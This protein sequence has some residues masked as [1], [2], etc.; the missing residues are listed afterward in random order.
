MTN[1]LLGTYCQN[2]L[3]WNQ[4][5]RESCRKCGATLMI[6]SR[7]H[8]PIPIK[9][10]EDEQNFEED[11]NLNEHLLERITGIEE[12]IRRI[13][14]YLETVSDQLGRLER[15]EVMLRNGLMSLVQEMEHSKLLDSQAFS[16]RWEELVEE[17]L[18]LISAREIFTRYRAR[19]LPIATPKSVAQLRR[20]LLETSTILDN[21]LLVEAT[22]YISRALDFDP[23]NYELIFTVASLKNVIHDFDEAEQLARQVVNL[24]PRHYEGWMLLAKIIDEDS[25]RFQETIEI[26]QTT[27]QLRPYEV[28]PKIHLANLL[29]DCG[30]IKQSLIHAKAAINIQ[31][32]SETL[33]ILAKILLAQGKILNAI[34]ILKEA[35]ILLPGD[36]RVKE[37]LAEAYIADNKKEKAF[38]IIKE[39]LRQNPEDESLELL[40][41]AQN[42]IQLNSARGGN[43]KVRSYLDTVEDCILDNDLVQAESILK[44]IKQED[45][46]ER[47]NWLELLLLFKQ[48]SICIQ[49]IIDFINS[50]HHPRL[51]FYA[52]R[53]VLDY[54]VKNNDQ[55]KIDNILEKFIEYHK[56]S[57]V[58]KEAIMIQ[59]AN[60]LV[61]GTFTTNDLE[62]VRQLHL[63][64][65]PGRE[66]QVQNLFGYY[67]LEFKCYIELENLI[68]P[69]TL[70][71]PSITNLFQ[72][73][74][75]LI[76]MQQYEEALNVLMDALDADYENLPKE[77]IELLRSNI[78]ELINDTKNKLS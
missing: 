52:L 31:R 76:A 58:V 46:N 44:T 56:D 72:L 43:L 23:K 61:D 17:N 39:L 34:K 65:P 9:P 60:H 68:R 10:W 38:L 69:I 50:N 53:L 73:G 14:T 77:Q 40:L 32:D 49:N 57:Y 19:I 78:T 66:T 12:T 16:L 5:E 47:F 45:K 11:N 24:S 30:E 18:Q 74:K 29:L 7:V 6:I 27:V 64:P 71:E 62:A 3:T 2:C 26:L 55:D 54:F 41:D 4:G 25:K 20:A 15:S 70:T 21:G 51:C 33:I 42:I 8:A 75:A 59:K 63:N 35:A 37:I 67:L 48:N 22:A 36:V 1:Y 28:S 13:E